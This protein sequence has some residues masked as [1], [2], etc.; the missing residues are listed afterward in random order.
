MSGHPTDRPPNI[1]FIMC[2]QLRWDYLSCNGHPFIRTPN[3][4][5]LARRGVRFNRTF[6][7]SPVCGPSRMSFYTGRTVNS[8]GASWNGLSLPVSEWTIGDYLK[9]AGYRVALA[10][11]THMRGDIESLNRLGIARDTPIG[12]YLAE[13]GFEAFDR[14]DGIHTRQTMARTGQPHYND[15]LRSLGYAG[16]NPWHDYANSVVDADGNVISGWDMRSARYP[17][18]VPEEHSE[19]AYITN[20]AMEF[21]GGA[22]ARPWLLH[23]SYIKPHWPYVAP[24]PY[25]AAYGG[26]EVVP[27][28]R[29]EAERHDPHPVYRAFM[30]MNASRSF[31][32]DEVRETVIPA[33]M[34]LVEQI[35][36]H[37]GRLLRFLDEQGDAANTVVVFTSDHG[38]YLGDHWLGEKELFHEASVRV[39]LIVYDPRPQADA[40]RGTAVDALVEAIDLLP[41]FIEMAGLPADRQRLEGRSLLGHIRG[42]TPRDWR[43]AVFS[44]LDYSHYA[45]RLALS[46]GPN[47]ARI[48]MVRT[49]AYKYLHYLGFPPQLYDLVADPQELTDLGRSPAHA[50]IR[51]ELQALLFDRL[52]RRRY[53]VTASD[54]AVEARTNK[55]EE[56]GIYIGRWSLK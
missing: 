29:S 12:L 6:V 21:I 48:F 47:D 37:V 24:A 46:L 1:L 11:K 2:D 32:R 31:A 43:D 39:P 10:G 40:A 54:A 28:V 26:N 23:L 38:D 52:A 30:D 33:Y 45:A 13:G 22:D 25:H 18:R 50:E 19:T 53:R 16:D 49:R 17:A 27:A 36:H 20:R 9:P 14:D 3:I 7:Q 8:H 55:E 5:A 41:T 56:V 34:G 15:W 44:E 4:D 35:D 51:A 42:E